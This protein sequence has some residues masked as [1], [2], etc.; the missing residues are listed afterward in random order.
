MIMAETMMISSIELQS[1]LCK[2]GLRT[3]VEL[4]NN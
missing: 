4:S 3:H 1:L 2:I